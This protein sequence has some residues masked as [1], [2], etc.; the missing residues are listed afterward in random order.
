[1]HLLGCQTLAPQGHGIERNSCGAEVW[2]VTRVSKAGVS[3]ASERSQWLRGKPRSIFHHLID[4]CFCGRQRCSLY[5]AW[6][7]VFSLFKI[8]WKNSTPTSLA[9]PL[10]ALRKQLDST[11]QRE[12][13]QHGKHN[14]NWERAKGWELIDWQFTFEPCVKVELILMIY[15]FWECFCDL[16]FFIW[17]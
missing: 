16:M 10:A 15:L 2:A 17:G 9:S 12:A 5:C 13:P 4:S 14:H 7:N 6:L 8:S 11:L 1:M 3:I